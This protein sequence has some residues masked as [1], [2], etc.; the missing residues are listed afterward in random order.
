MP[1][2]N[3]ALLQETPSPEEVEAFIW[4]KENTPA[5]ATV[6][7]TLDEGH[8]VTYYAERKNLMDDRF[9][10][11]DDVENRFQ[12]LTSL[13]TTKFQT[14]ALEI[15]DRYNLEYFV[16]TP[17]AKEKYQL[18][19]EISYITRRC[20]DTIYQ[21]ETTIFKLKCKLGPT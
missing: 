18:K 8:L 19:K 21:N 20:F 9:M 13:F 16:L 14:E 5:S 6:L 10:L 1:A 15:A 3:T 12:S 2:L 4:I 17:S 7:A 11:V